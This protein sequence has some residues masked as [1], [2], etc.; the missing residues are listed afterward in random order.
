M[1]AIPCLLLDYAGVP[2]QLHHVAY[3]LLWVSVGLS[4]ISGVQ[5]STG[6]RKA[7]TSV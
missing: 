2:S 5:Y 3:S 4:L 1:I 7:R 6:Y